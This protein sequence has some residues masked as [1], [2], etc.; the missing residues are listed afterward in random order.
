MRIDEVTTLVLMH[1]RSGVVGGSSMNAKAISRAACGPG[2][3]D[4]A[5]Q[6]GADHVIEYT[7]DDYTRDEAPTT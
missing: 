1:A 4:L 7:Q 2:K 5:G 3:V 6:L